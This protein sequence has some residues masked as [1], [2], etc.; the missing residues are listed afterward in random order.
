MIESSFKYVKSK[1]L[2]ACMEYM[3]PSVHVATDGTVT[4]VSRN[5][6]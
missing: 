4:K 6:G 1:L 3:K 2:D 5:E